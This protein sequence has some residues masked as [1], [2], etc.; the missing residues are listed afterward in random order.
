MVGVFWSFWE[1]GVGFSGGKQK[2]GRR[3]H[4][5]EWWWWKGGER[6]AEVWIVEAN[7]NADLQNCVQTWNLFIVHILVAHYELL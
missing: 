5:G 6:V 3:W 4:G 2:L 7:P 1:V